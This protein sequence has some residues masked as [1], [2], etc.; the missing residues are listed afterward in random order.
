MNVACQRQALYVALM[1]LR[2]L[3]PSLVSDPIHMVWFGAFWPTLRLSRPA[4]PTLPPDPLL[5]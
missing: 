3:D 1:V 4:L 2:A 5:R